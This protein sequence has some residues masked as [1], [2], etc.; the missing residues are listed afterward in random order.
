MKT[1]IDQFLAEQNS[2]LMQQN[3]LLT[4]QVDSLKSILSDYSEIE[5]S[6]KNK[7]SNL[8]SEKEIQQALIST[9]KNE[10]FKIGQ[11]NWSEQLQQAFQE[12][13]AT[14]LQQQLTQAL[15]QLN[16]NSIINNLVETELTPIQQRITS[17]QDD[18]Q[19]ALSKISQLKVSETIYEDLEMQSKQIVQLGQTLENLTTLIKNLNS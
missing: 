12:N 8:Q 4:Q 5:Q 1:E 9:L 17:Q 15:N 13:L 6:L 2:L 16:L 3:A 19:Q 11:G 14:Q 7:I 18:L 10:L